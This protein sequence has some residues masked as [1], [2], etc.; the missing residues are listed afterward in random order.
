MTDY[1]FRAYRRAQKQ[2]Y[3]TPTKHTEL[4]HSAYS[5]RQVHACSV[6]R[7]STDV[8]A[9]ADAGCYSLMTGC[10]PWSCSRRV[11]LHSSFYLLAGTPKQLCP[12]PTQRDCYYSLQIQNLS[13]TYISTRT[14]TNTADAPK[15]KGKASLQFFLR[16]S[17]GSL[18][19]S[20]PLRRVVLLSF[21]CWRAGDRPRRLATS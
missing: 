8:K 6:P 17:R 16:F 13:H 5:E 4:T 9:P 7:H 2:L 11:T 10:F 15:T 14:P 21:V 3:P 20:H 19:A 18:D 1:G 12:P